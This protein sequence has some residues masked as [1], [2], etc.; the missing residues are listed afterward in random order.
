MINVDVTLHYISFLSSFVLIKM[1]NDSRFQEYISKGINILQSPSL[2][3]KWW[4]QMH[5]VI[6]KSM[7]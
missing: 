1:Y 7:Q 5:V 6:E 2:K 3:A 4:L